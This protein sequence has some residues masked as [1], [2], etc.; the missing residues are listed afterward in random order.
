MNSFAFS[1]SSYRINFSAEVLVQEILRGAPVETSDLIR[2]SSLERTTREPFR[3]RREPLNTRI[4]S[5]T[6][7]AVQI[8]A[9]AD[10]GG[11]IFAGN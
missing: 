5:L 7:I 2:P 3:R 11:L 1:R 10:I 6:I 8:Y 9:V 4:Y